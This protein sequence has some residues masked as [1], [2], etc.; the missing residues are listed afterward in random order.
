MCTC[1]YIPKPNGYLLG[2]NRDESPLRSAKVIWDDSKTNQRLWYPQEPVAG[3]TNLGISNRDRI[4]CLLNG[5]SHRSHLPGPF[6]RSR[7]LVVLDSFETESMLPFYEQYD[8]GGI[9]EFTLLAF[10]QKQISFME[11][12]G[13]EVEHHLVDP[14]RAHIWAA[15]ML[16]SNEWQARRREWLAQFL[17]NHP[18]P[19]AEDLYQFHAT[20]GVGNPYQDMVMNRKNLVKTVSITIIEKSQDHFQMRHQNLLNDE[21]RH[22]SLTIQKNQ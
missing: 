17:T 14:S 21:V 8:F 22:F 12:D 13:R 2:V 10:D 7:G 1:T 3:G 5:S 15:P 6:G 9:N 20:G 18:E 11:W 4:I 19:T 16:Y